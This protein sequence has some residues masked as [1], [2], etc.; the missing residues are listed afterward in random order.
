[1][2]PYGCVEPRGALALVKLRFRIGLAAEKLQMN[3]EAM[4]SFH[5]VLRYDKLNLSA[6]RGIASILRAEDKYDQAV[7][8]IRSI[9]TAMP[10]DGESWAAL[11]MEYIPSHDRRGTDNVKR[12]LL[13]YDG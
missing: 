8:Y 12:T 13:S 9:I 6:L 10:T 7:E 5:Q 11:G 2:A 4:D 1:M 3:V